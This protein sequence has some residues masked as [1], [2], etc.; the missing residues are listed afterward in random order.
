MTTINTNSIDSLG[1]SAPQS[2]KNESLGQD[3]FLKLMVAQLRHQDP[4]EP[5]QNGEFL[6]QMAQFGTVSGIEE[7]QTSISQLADSLYSNQALQASSLVGRTVLAPAETGVLPQDGSLQG[8]LRL[9]AGTNAA[10]LN[11]YDL[12]GNLVQRVDLGSIPAGDLSF[13]WDGTAEDGTK[14]PAGKYRVEAEAAFNGQTVAV[15][16]L[17]GSVVNSVSLGGSQGGLVLN[18]EDGSTLDFVNVH[19]IM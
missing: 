3:E 19:Q 12:S 16:T 18:L 11:I 2:Q 7:M 10:A 17:I 8:T 13:E 4:F 15:D 6:T 1:L 14:M 5:M 9:P